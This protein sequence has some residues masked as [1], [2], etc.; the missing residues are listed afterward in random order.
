MCSLARST[1]RR[2][3]E[4]HPEQDENRCNAIT[5]GL[6]TDPVAGPNSTWAVAGD[7]RVVC[8]LGFLA[9][10]ERL[11]LSFKIFTSLIPNLNP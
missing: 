9:E 2:G 10:E 3:S 11:Q 7:Y 8:M 1:D 6:S 5:L 4:S